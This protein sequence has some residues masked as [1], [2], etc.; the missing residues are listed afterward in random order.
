MEKYGKYK[1]N[2]KR[3][4]PKAITSYGVICTTIIRKN[5]KRK[6]FYLFTQRRD[7]IAYIEFFRDKVKQADM[8]KIISLMSKDEKKRILSCYNNSKL[9]ELWYDL[10]VDERIKAFISEFDKVMESC[11]KNI[12][13]YKHYFENENIGLEENPWLFPKG[14]KHLIETELD[15]SLR[16]FEE[17][18]LI[19]KDNLTV[20]PIKPLEEFF[21]GFDGKYY[22]TVYFT[23]YIPYHLI[24]KNVYKHSQFRP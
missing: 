10:W 23:A 24:P 19:S 3:F 8:F 14:R 13:K 20:L 5:G 15:C 12:K 22:R 9:D 1:Y 21:F 2:Y 16:E 17:E 11:K 7:T 18:T 6:I 4:G